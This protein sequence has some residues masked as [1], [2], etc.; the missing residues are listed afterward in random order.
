MATIDVSLPDPMKDWVEEQARSGRYNDP[1]DYVRE[2]IRR[3]QERASAI[4]D[5]ERLID[6]GFESGVSD[7]PIDEVFADARA[8][9]RA[10][11]TP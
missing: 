11:Q 1:G 6:E 3:D 10:L 4:S 9:T 7:R 2:L 5:L 8:R